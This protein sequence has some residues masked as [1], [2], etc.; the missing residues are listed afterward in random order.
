MQRVAPNIW[1]HLDKRGQRGCVCGAGNMI[2]VPHVESPSSPLES[3][4][5]SLF[6][7]PMANPLENLSGIIMFYPLGA[8]LNKSKLRTQLRY[9]YRFYSWWAD[10][11]SG[12]WILNQHLEIC[13]VHSNLMYIAMHHGFIFNFYQ[14]H[15]FPWLVFPKKGRPTGRWRFGQPQVSS[16]ANW[17]WHWQRW[18][19]GY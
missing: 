9:F 8:S 13:D 6:T 16:S 1:S 12:W 17:I 7:F 4:S 19:S 2:C 3:L 15:I 10:E 5:S 18:W 11:Q 14:K